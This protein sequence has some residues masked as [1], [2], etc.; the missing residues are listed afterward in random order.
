MGEDKMEEEKKKEGEMHMEQDNVPVD[1]QNKDA[2][3]G[4]DAGGGS[5]TTA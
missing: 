3:G 1:C 4:S 5:S 2:T